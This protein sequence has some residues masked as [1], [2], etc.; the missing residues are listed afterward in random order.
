MWTNNAVIVTEFHIKQITSPKTS[1]RLIVKSNTK[2]YVKSI[3]ELS[4]ICENKI[5]ENKEEIIMSYY[6]K[7]KLETIIFALLPWFNG[8][9]EHMQSFSY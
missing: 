1:A 7:K 8:A 3:A 9:K 5:L 6:L 4:V 2:R